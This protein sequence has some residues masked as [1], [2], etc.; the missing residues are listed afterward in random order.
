MLT[1]K[2]SYH[3]LNI[4]CRTRVY[5]AS[6]RIPFYNARHRSQRGICFG[7]YGCTTCVQEGN[8][9]KTKVYLYI[10]VI[11]HMWLARNKYFMKH[12]IIL[13][14]YSN[15][16]CLPLENKYAEDSDYFPLQSIAVHFRK[17]RMIMV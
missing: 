1:Q 8:G 17:L 5:K 9:K 16:N 6:R 10:R 3:V 4:M 11:Y 14:S 13:L 2:H 7:S 12:V 15:M